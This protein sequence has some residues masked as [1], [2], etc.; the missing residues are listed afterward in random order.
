VEQQDTLKA[1][2]DDTQNQRITSMW[3]VGGLAIMFFLQ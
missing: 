2:A 1:V 3:F